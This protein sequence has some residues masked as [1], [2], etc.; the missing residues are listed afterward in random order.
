MVEAFVIYWKERNE[1]NR[2]KRGLGRYNRDL[3][4]K[5]GVPAAI[6]MIFKMK[7]PG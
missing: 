7:V 1:G 2:I 6:R 3:G 4:K 5:E